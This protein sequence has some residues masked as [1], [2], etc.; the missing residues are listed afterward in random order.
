MAQD[1]GALLRSV[2]GADG[3]LRRR[4]LGAGGIDQ[5]RRFAQREGRALVMRAP[6]NET[7]VPKG[8]TPLRALIDPYGQNSAQAIARRRRESQ[9]GH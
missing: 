2:H 5:V 6:S 8:A 1:L 3:V 9:Y 4:H 7:I